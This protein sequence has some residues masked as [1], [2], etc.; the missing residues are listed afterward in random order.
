MFLQQR[1][2]WKD[3]SATAADGGFYELLTSFPGAEIISVVYFRNIYL[4]SFPQTISPG[5]SSLPAF[6]PPS[7]R[8]SLL[9]DGISEKPMLNLMWLLLRWVLPLITLKGGAEFRLW[10]TCWRLC[11]LHCGGLSCQMFVGAYFCQPQCLTID[12]SVMFWQQKPNSS[13]PLRPPLSRPPSLSVWLSSQKA[14]KMTRNHIHMWENKCEEK[15]EVEVV[16]E[17]GGSGGED[18]VKHDFQPQLCPQT[19]L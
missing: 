18:G 14:W 3:S 10:A 13:E 19:L 4:L 11:T 6:S 2:V 12:P 7:S 16:G 5:L 15:E 9:L 8:T 1:K 17:G